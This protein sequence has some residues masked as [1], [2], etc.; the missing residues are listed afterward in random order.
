MASDDECHSGIED[1]GLHQGSRF[2]GSPPDESSHGRSFDDDGSSWVGSQDGGSNVQSSVDE[3][4][5]NDSNDDLYIQDLPAPSPGRNSYIWNHFQKP[6]DKHTV[7]L[8]TPSSPSSSSSSPPLYSEEYR[9]I[10]A[11]AARWAT[12][13]AKLIAKAP[14]LSSTPRIENCEATSDSIQSV[15]TS[16]LR[17]LPND[18]IS[19]R[20]YELEHPSLR[21]LPKFTVGPSKRNSVQDGNLEYSA[22]ETSSIHFINLLNEAETELL[23]DISNLPC[24]KL[25]IMQ[26]PAVIDKYFPPHVYRSM[27][28]YPDLLNGFN[29]IR[30]LESATMPERLSLAIMMARTD[31][32]SQPEGSQGL[33]RPPHMSMTVEGNDTFNSGTSREDGLPPAVDNHPPSTPQRQPNIFSRR[34]SATHVQLMPIAIDRRLA[35]DSPTAPNTSPA[36]SNDAGETLGNLTQLTQRLELVSSRTDEGGVVP[37]SRFTSPDNRQGK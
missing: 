34:S 37:Q 26:K 18:Q 10:D 12:Q 11:S 31:G 3:S 19:G 16:I 7:V 22:C 27:R 35:I 29:A 17:P 2:E 4:S 21:T 30:D 14:P 28:C 32:T 13:L 23:I 33:E 5:I 6:A 8:G 25:E 1:H 36:L 20:D 15:R 24:K 9:A